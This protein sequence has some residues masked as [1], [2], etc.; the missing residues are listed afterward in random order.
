MTNKLT[1]KAQGYTQKALGFGLPF[2]TD[3]EEPLQHFLSLEG[4]ELETCYFMRGQRQGSIP[5]VA[6]LPL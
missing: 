2:A 5:V 1:G 6:E 3:Y 4:I